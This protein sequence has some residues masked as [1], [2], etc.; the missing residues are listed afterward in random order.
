MPLLTDKGVQLATITPSGS[1]KRD[2][3]DILCTFVIPAFRATKK[4]TGVAS[5]KAEPNRQQQVCL[6]IG[7]KKHLS[8]PATDAAEHLEHHHNEEHA[9]L[10]QE[11]H[12]VP[13]ETAHGSRFIFLYV[14]VAIGFLVGLAFLLSKP[15]LMILI[16]M[17]IVRGNKR[18]FG[19][20]DTES[21]FGF[22]FGHSG[23]GRFSK[24][25]KS[26]SVLPRSN[27]ASEE[28][29]F[30]VLAGGGSQSLGPRRGA[31]AKNKA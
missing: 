31:A 16:N 27:S 3:V 23:K 4:S 28:E 19:V 5:K 12:T 22:G 21:G 2:L 7:N 30:V 11:E 6:A 20:R 25:K 10:K 1:P 9:G 13:H 17:G 18:V 8:P 26:M 29:G 15:F 14:L 24:D